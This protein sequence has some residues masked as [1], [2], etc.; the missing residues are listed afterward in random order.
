MARKIG[1]SGALRFARLFVGFLTRNRERFVAFVDTDTEA[2]EAWDDCIS[3][4][5]HLITILVTKVIVGD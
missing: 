5:E 3:C 1:V 4:A 2:I